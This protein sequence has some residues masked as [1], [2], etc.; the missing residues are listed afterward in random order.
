MQNP[1]NAS[2]PTDQEQ[3][4]T[5]GTKQNDLPN[6][7]AVIVGIAALGGAALLFRLLSK[8]KRE[9]QEASIQQVTGEYIDALHQKQKEADR[10]GPDISAAVQAQNSAEASQLLSNINKMRHDGIMEIIKKMG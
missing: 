6:T 7:A 2:S 9:K 8:G 3:N 1:N 10:A 4:E 5:S